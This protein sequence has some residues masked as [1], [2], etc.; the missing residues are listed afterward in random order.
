MKKVEDTQLFQ[1]FQHPL[2]R[3]LWHCLTEL[4]YAYPMAE[5]WIR[6]RGFPLWGIQRGNTTEVS[7][8]HG[9]YLEVSG[10]D[11]G[12]LLSSGSERKS[13]LYSV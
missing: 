4:S 5:L 11:V 12:S 8:P 7:V 10:H 6:Q 3:R 13:T 2:W 9:K 1:K